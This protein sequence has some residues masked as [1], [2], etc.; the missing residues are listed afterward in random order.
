[1][2]LHLRSC[3]GA[4]NSNSGSGDRVKSEGCAGHT[5]F[6]VLYMLRVSI[7]EMQSRAK[8]ILSALHGLPITATIGAGRAQV[9]G[10]TLPQSV[11]ES[12]TLDLTHGTLKPQEIANR[13]R[14]H[15]VPIVGYVARGK[16]KL[17]LRTIF[18]RQDAELTA[19]IRALY[20]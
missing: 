20:V 4:S 9:G 12:V 17:D 19:A 6:P 7:G 15:R 14:G 3:G 10:G 2:D 18:P 8:S 5:D 11:L 16:F 1:V 13:M